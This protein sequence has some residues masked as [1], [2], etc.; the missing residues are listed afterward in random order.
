M[1]F[2]YPIQY[3]IWSEWRWDN[4]TRLCNTNIWNSATQSSHYREISEWSTN[5]A[6]KSPSDFVIINRITFSKGALH[7]WCTK[8]TKVMILALNRIHEDMSQFPST[9]AYP[10][11]RENVIKFVEITSF[12]IFVCLRGLSLIFKFRI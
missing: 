6:W 5:D 11:C 4:D 8:A 9:E 1:A 3:G 2:V 7:S 10:L 12:Y